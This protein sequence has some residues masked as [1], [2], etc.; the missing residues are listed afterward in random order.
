[1]PSEFFF[2]YFFFHESRQKDR[3]IY[4]QTTSSHVNGFILL[5]SLFNSSNGFTF[6][7]CFL[8]PPIWLDSMRFSPRLLT[9]LQV[10]INSDA[11]L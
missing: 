10:E 6:G 8:L 1:M 4:R 7:K 11:I 9:I 2:V 5:K 3:Q